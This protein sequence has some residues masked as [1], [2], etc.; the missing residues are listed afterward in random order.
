MTSQLVFPAVGQA[1]DHIF[2]GTRRNLLCQEPAGQ[3]WGSH[4][5]LTKQ[6]ANKSDISCFQRTISLGNARLSG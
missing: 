2:Q 4:T 5:L 1:G 6:Y 3:Q